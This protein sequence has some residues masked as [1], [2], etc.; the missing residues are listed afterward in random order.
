M[1]SSVIEMDSLNR[2]KEDF[3]CGICFSDCAI[4]S[5]VKLAECSHHIC[6][7]CLRHTIERHVDEVEIPCPYSKSYDSCACFLTDAE[8][9]GVAS[10]EDYKKF[11][12]IGT[13]V[14]QFVF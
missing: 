2:N 1:D 3:C 7:L 4:G 12:K 8:I 11:K 13:V 9:K 14:S 10:E 6:E 5:G